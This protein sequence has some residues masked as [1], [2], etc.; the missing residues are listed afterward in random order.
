M[1][2]EWYKDS[3]TKSLWIHILL[4]ANYSY[5]KFKGEPVCAGEFIT[6][7]R[8][9]SEETGLSVKEVR[10]ALNHLKRT[11]EIRVEGANKYTKIIVEKWRYFQVD[12][13][14]MG[15]DIFD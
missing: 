7:I 1:D 8:N 14:E 6:T 5:Q 13:C 11:H 15:T 12:E 4:R 10:T 3:K 2:W 9:L